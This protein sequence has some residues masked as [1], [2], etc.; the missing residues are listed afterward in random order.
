M[1]INNN[2]KWETARNMMMGS[3]IQMGKYI[4]TLREGAKV[5]SAF[6]ISSLF[7]ILTINLNNNNNFKVAT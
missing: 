6:A 2:F 5:V 3:H 4:Y 1:H 7:K